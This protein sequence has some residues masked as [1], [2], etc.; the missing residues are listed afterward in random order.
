MDYKRILVVCIDRDGDI[1]T[2]IGV[3]GPI[4]GRANV[5]DSAVRLGLTD[6]RESDTNALFEAVRMYDELKEEGKDVE[7]AALVGSENVGYESDSILSS[8]LDVVIGGERPDGIVVVTDGVEDEYVLP[9]VQSRGKVI[10]L[11]RVIVKQSEQLE[12]T[13]YVLQEFLKELVSDPKLSRLFIGV[14]GIA[15]ILYMILGQHGWRLIVGVVGVFLTIKGFSLEDTV[16]RVYDEL[17]SSFISGK[18]SFFTYVVATIIALVGVVS[19]YN[20]ISGQGLATRELSTLVPLFISGS[21]DL[22]LFACFVA[23]LG[24]VMDA[25]VEGG[26]VSKYIILGVF[27]FALRIILDAVSRFML[28]NMDGVNLAFS[29]ALGLVLSMFAFFSIRSRK[30]PEPATPEESEKAVQ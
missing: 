16:Q 23:L 22:L 17:R 26:V 2:K 7:I 30:V 27:A 15:A 14:P 10:S 3:K 8:Q 11:R 29:V 4:I 28:G 20:A 21:V 24:K 13:Y 6:P 12:S 9:L 5:F 18:I 19:G 1:H 25:I